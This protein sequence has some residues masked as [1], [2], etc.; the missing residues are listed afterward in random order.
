MRAPV[1]VHGDM[2]DIDTFAAT[3]DIVAQG[4]FDFQF[5][6]GI[7]AELYPVDDLARDPAIFRHPGDRSETHAGRLADLFQYRPNPIVITV[8]RDR[9]SEIVPHRCTSFDAMLIAPQ[10]LAA[11]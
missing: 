5:P 10:H 9:G 1:L 2:I 11:I 7:K 8:R 6:A 3:A 4:L